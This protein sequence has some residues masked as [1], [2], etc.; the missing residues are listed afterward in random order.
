VGQDVLLICEQDQPS[1]IL[2]RFAIVKP[3]QQVNVPIGPDRQLHMNVFFLRGFLG[4]DERT[5]QEQSGAGILP[6]DD[7]PN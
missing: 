2:S 4:Y 6:R 3:L 1:E 5:Y 7:V